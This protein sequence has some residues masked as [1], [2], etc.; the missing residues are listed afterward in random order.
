ML[1]QFSELNHQPFQTL[2]EQ[3]S[4]GIMEIVDTSTQNMDKIQ[5]KRFVFF[6]V[7]TFQLPNIV[8]T[9]H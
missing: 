4:I 8:S 5:M 7:L 1:F 6:G 2:C 9:R 3:I